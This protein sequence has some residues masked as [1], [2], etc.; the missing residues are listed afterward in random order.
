MRVLIEGIG[1]F[2]SMFKARN[3]PLVSGFVLGHNGRGREIVLTRAMVQC[4][5]LSPSF[6]VY[7]VSKASGSLHRVAEAPEPQL[8]FN[9]KKD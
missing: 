8:E 5:G 3:C 2:D 6:I 1:T 4:S 9:F 7:A